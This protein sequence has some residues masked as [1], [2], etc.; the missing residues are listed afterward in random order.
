MTLPRWPEPEDDEARFAAIDQYTR[1]LQDLDERPVYR[2]IADLLR[3]ARRA[4][5]DDPEPP[6]LPALWY[7]Q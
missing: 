6:R 1:R 7:E 2:L 5:L 3:R 4:E